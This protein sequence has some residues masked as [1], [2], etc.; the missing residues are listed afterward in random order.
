MGNLL[1]VPLVLAALLQVV[2]G[3]GAPK[4]ATSLGFTTRDVLAPLVAY[5]L[6]AVA[7]FAASVVLLLRVPGAIWLAVLAGVLIC[8]APLLWG[9]R[10]TSSRRATTSCA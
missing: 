1:L 9:T 3:L 10:R 8:A 6:A 5:W 7:S 2:A 4:E